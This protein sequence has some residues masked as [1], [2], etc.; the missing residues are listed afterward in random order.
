MNYLG[1]DWGE[2][3]IG[4]AFADSLGIAVPLP[5]AVAST[6]QA[7][8]QQIEAAI[9]ERKIEALVVGYPL[10]MDGSVGFKAKE[11]EAFIAVLE[12]RFKLPVHRLDERLSSHSVE[13]H[14]KGSKKKP[15][16]KSGAIDSSAAALILQDF[17]E[18]QRFRSGFDEEDESN[19]ER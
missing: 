15:D 9:T 17:I 14:L 1:I 7:R 18:E 6:K 4:L 19:V 10:N 12:G 11:V 13:Q 8:M 2:K 5:A 16:R 3:R